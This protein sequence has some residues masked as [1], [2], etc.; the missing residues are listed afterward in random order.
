[1]KQKAVLFGLL[2]NFS[3]VLT[4]IMLSGKRVPKAMLLVFLTA[5]VS[6][7][8]Y[9]RL[10]SGGA[11]NISPKIA[12]LSVLLALL[13]AFSISGLTVLKKVDIKIEATGDKNMHSQSAEV[14]FYLEENGR[15]IDMQPY[16]SDKWMYRDGWLISHQD[17]PSKIRLKLADVSGL[18]VVFLKHGWSGKTI[19][20]E[21]G[22]YSHIDLYSNYATNFRYEPLRGTISAGGT[23]KSMLP[24]AEL[25]FLFLYSALA[26]IAGRFGETAKRLSYLA[27][28]VFF[29][30]LFYNAYW[31][32]SFGYLSLALMIA[33]IY[34][35]LQAV[36]AFLAG[37]RA[38]REY[39]PGRVYPAVFIL[40]ACY[41]TAALTFEH[42]FPTPVAAL[43]LPNVSR[44]ILVFMWVLAA[45]HG[46]LKLLKYAGERLPAARDNCPVPDFA[47]WP[48]VF[49]IM[50]SA[51]TVWFLAFYPATMSPDS[52]DQYGQAMGI[53]ALHNAHPV[54]HTL[55]I[56]LGY[57][58]TKSPGGFTA[59]QITAMAG[60]FT[61]ALHSMRRLGLSKNAVL[62]VAVI[63]ALLPN[64]GIFSVT[65]W[66][67]VPTALA[68]LCAT[69]AMIN[70]VERG[71]RASFIIFALS[72]GVLPFFRHNAVISTI[73]CLAFCFIY[74]GCRKNRGF[75]FAGT[76]A[77]VILIAGNIAVSALNIPKMP[78]KNAYNYQMLHGMAAVL[79]YGGELDSSANRMLTK[80]LDIATWRDSYVPAVILDYLFTPEYR[81]AMDAMPTSRLINSY[82]R[83]F[84]HHPWTVMYERLDQSG[85]L[86]KMYKP[87]SPLQPL[88]YAAD[89]YKNQ[90]DLAHTDSIM[91]NNLTAG[92]WNINNDGMLHTILFRSGI[93][94]AILLLTGYFL[95]LNRRGY[96]LYSYLPMLGLTA[97]IAAI[98]AHPEFRYVYHIFV[99]WIFI[100]FYAV[101]P[102]NKNSRE[103]SAG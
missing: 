23:L 36:P 16:A 63:I 17:Q 43:N 4:L 102:G 28:S 72:I 97:T 67:D 41:I 47:F 82:F 35:G 5:A 99:T 75:I 30:F 92:L 76:A 53:A 71:G 88:P 56:R 69:I 81:K 38:L 89:I 34:L 3:V 45:Q 85:T 42:I 61:Y 46:F 95:V 87:S 21:R 57:F 7:Y 55:L 26:A 18:S 101:L 15:R 48:A 2:L 68:I 93:Y 103:S 50:L 40:T 59:L 79:N 1:M 33:F 65:M 31:F 44:V 22:K 64:N 29:V 91:R 96:R 24:A 25:F 12:A 27:L 8:V 39:T 9:R 70:A 32:Q 83:T 6:V 78:L 51:W 98:N 86:W 84:L 77:A 10:K 13:S 14:W 37:G 52:V 62:A 80:N 19:I 74:G 58:L 54:F 11:F 90:L 66:K 100:V 60:V 73:F 20:N 49:F 94:V